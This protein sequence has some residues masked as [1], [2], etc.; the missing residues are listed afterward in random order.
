LTQITT[1]YAAR[2][3]PFWAENWS[4]SP[5]KIIITLTPETALLPKSIKRQPI[6]QQ[7]SHGTKI[8]LAVGQGDQMSLKKSPKM[9]PNLIFCQNNIQQKKVASKFGMLPT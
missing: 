7:N 5:L 3:S 9:L 6:L 8:K 1:Q 2:K 4:K